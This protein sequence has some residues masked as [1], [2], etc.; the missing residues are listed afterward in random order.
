[1]I[2]YSPIDPTKPTDIYGRYFEM[3]DEKT[4]LKHELLPSY[5]FKLLKC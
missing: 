4:Y 2:C 3:I 1:M 5:Q